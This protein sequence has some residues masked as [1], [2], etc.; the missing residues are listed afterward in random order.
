M[1]QPGTSPEIIVLTIAGAIA[2]L[3][4][5]WTWADENRRRR[6]LVRWL[7]TRHADLWNQLP[8][9]SRTLNVI[10]AIEQLRR[11]GLSANAEFMARYDEV[12]RRKGA[13]RAAL[14]V[15]MGFI[16]AVIIG[17]RYLGWDF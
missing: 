3:Y 1:D 2:S 15:G 6:R 17:T 12:K 10:G 8:R 16:G 9:G 5:W 14:V 4:A 7:R 11:N 13:A